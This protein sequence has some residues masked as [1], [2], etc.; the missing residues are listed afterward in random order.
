MECPKCGRELL[1]DHVKEKDGVKEFYYAC[2]NK[3]CSERG[4]AFKP[5]GEIAKS[6]IKTE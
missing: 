2:I 3:G 5:T 6:T 4:K 1:L